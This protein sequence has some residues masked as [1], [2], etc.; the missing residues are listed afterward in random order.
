VENIKK[1]LKTDKTGLVSGFCSIPWTNITV[2]DSGLIYACQCNG[3]VKKPICNILD[4]NSKEEFISILNDNIIKRSILDKSYRL[5]NS[6]VC[7]ELQDNILFNKKTSQFKENKE[8][9][10]KLKL[11]E[12][13]MQVDESCNLQCP[14]C[15]NDIIIHKNNQKTKKL[16]IILDRLQKYIFEEANDLIYLR[17]VGNGELFASHTMLPWFLKFDFKKYPNI[18]FD[19]HTNATLLSRHEN[20]L[21]SIADKIRRIEV[22]TDAGT[23][24]TYSIVRKNG[25]W[26]DLLK[27]Y[28]TIQKLRNVNNNISLS[29][30]FVV[31]SLNYNDI[32]E[33]I[34]FADSQNAKIIFYKVVRWNMDDEKFKKL[35]IF[36]SQHDEY[37]AFQKIIHNINFK[38]DKH[39]TNI[40]N[41]KLN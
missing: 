3:Y 20:Y 38:N 40:F 41:I 28:S 34:K 11:K 31:S 8:K 29:S 21:L 2:T 15:R 26:N 14:T 23:K 17:I 36:S 5:C 18:R 6:I 10:E 35:N 19:L 7:H 12:I 25:D 33:F 9:L 1:L 37:N 32:E 4:V 13:L 39:I 24:E 16:E 30:S 22:S 27:G